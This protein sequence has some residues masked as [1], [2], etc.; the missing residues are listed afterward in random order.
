M[1]ATRA[2]LAAFAAAGALLA[3]AASPRADDVV[4]TWSFKTSAYEPNCSMVGTLY[5]EP[6]PTNGVYKCKLKAAE[7]CGGDKYNAEESCTLSEKSGAVTIT[8]KITYASVPAY[9]PDDFTL[10]LE[11]RQRMSGQLRSAG[12]VAPVI[13]YRGPDIIS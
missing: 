1:N 7:T 8:S 13:F 10:K 6:K 2:T 11:N 5:V 9:A 4:G 12:L 3:A